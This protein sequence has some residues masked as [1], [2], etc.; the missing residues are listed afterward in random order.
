ML[1]VALS[2]RVEMTKIRRKK[3]ATLKP[4]YCLK[5][6]IQAASPTYY[7]GDDGPERRLDETFVRLNCLIVETSE[8]LEQH[9]GKEIEIRLACERFLPDVSQSAK[10]AHLSLTLRK[11][12]RSMVAYLPSDAIWALPGLI[13]SK[14]ITHV[15]VDCDELHRG[16]A[17][18]LSIYFSTLAEM[19]SLEAHFV[20]GRQQDG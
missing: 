19:H 3:K 2:E 16:E 5:A 20:E 6:E 13:A 18:G 9:R 15:Q 12:L 7:L 1:T 17:T 4:V 14:A 11:N 10:R 8:K